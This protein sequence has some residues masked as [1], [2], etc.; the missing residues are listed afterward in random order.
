[1]TISWLGNNGFRIQTKDVTLVMDLYDAENGLKAPR[2]GAADIL[3]F[4]S[5]DR[6]VKK[7]PQEAFV[8]TG[9]GEYEIKGVFIYGHAVNGTVIYIVNVEGMQL[10]HL[11]MLKNEEIPSEA[12]DHMEQ[13]DILFLPVGGGNVLDA[14]AAVRVAQNIE[15]RMIIPMMYKTQGVTGNLA[16]VDAF[17]KEMGT[18]DGETV[19]KLKVS[20]KDLPQDKTTVTVIQLS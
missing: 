7:G 2:I 8:I 13:A 14:K 15:P 18:K 9:P 1:M 5:P 4:S 11:G 19:D 10:V 16:S 6:V 12:L 17:L 20:L 3:T